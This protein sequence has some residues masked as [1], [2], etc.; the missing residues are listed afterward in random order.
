MNAEYIIP[1]IVAR[2]LPAEEE[3]GLDG[4]PPQG[5]PAELLSEWNT[6][7]KYYDLSRHSLPRPDW[8]VQG[9]SESPH[10]AWQRLK[11]LAGE[12]SGAISI[13]VHIPFCASRCAFC[14]CHAARAARPDSDE[15]T[16]YIARL[17]REA[18]RWSGCGILARRPVTTVHF[19]GG[20]ANYISPAC[21]RAVVRSLRDN[22]NITPETEFAL[23]TTCRCLMPLH[24]TALSTNGFKRIHIGVQ[25]LQPGLRRQLGRPTPPEQVIERVRESLDEGW[26]V[27]AD[28][29]YGLPRQ[30]CADLL[31]DVGAL[32]MAGVHGVSLY[33][34]NASENNHAFILR[35]GLDRRGPQDEMRN[36]VSFVS[37]ARYLRQAG[38]GKTHFAHYSRLEDRNLYSRCASRGEDLLALG[39]YADGYFGAYYYRHLGLEGYRAA[40]DQASALEGGG[41]FNLRAGEAQQMLI[42]LMA[43]TLSERTIHSGWQHELIRRW[44]SRGILTGPDSAGAWDLSDS[45]S[46]VLPQCLLDLAGEAT[47]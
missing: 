34:L 3:V 46:W 19:G 29:L 15:I 16:D 24:R 27:S 13:Y 38:F 1:A 23:E 42:H 22:F 25:T 44:R 28:L 14:D 5:L 36:Y 41:F 33:R 8:M 2:P 43:N 47:K 30:S 18:P 37:A 10:R 39:A 20:T 35:Y 40:E 6:V 17:I 12:R 7:R 32:V 4:T 26:I 31:E 45:G 11:Q 21:F 9:F